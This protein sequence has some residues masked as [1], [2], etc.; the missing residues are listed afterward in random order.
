M[1]DFSTMWEAVADCPVPTIAKIEGFCLGGGLEL[2][3]A[4]DLRIASETSEFGFPE[5]NLGLIPGAGGTQRIQD[6]LGESRA[7]ELVFRGKQIEADKAEEWGLIN[8]SVVPD[9]FDTFAEDFV[10]DIASGPPVALRMAKKVMDEG[11]DAPHDA[12]I[13]M[14]REAFGLLLTTDDLMEGLA[15]FTDDDKEPDFKGE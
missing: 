2:A 12:G 5:I 9:D 7:K 4:C 1:L 14:E 13:T 10:D 11:Q 3:L 8:H 15:A 6:V